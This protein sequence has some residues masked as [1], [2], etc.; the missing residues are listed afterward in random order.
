MVK[1]LGRHISAVTQDSN[2]IFTGTAFDSPSL[3]V[4]PKESRV[5]FAEIQL[6]Y[7]LLTVHYWKL[8]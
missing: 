1:H 2:R 7:E 6:W 3:S 8:T 4:A 5:N